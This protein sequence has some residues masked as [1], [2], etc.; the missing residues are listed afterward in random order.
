MMPAQLLR[1]AEDLVGSAPLAP[2]HRCDRPTTRRGHRGHY[3]AP[4]LPWCVACMRLAR[5]AGEERFWWR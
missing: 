3:E 4:D 5:A 2:C 1:D